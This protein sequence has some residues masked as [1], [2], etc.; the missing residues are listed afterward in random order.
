MRT[1]EHNCLSDKERKYLSPNCSKPPQ[2][3]GLPK[4]HKENIPLRPI[5][6]AFGLPTYRLAK[7]L[8]RI[9]TPL[10]G[11]T[12]T[13]VKNSTEFVRRIK[14]MEPQVGEIIV[15]FDVVSLF[16]KVPIQEAIQAIH[17]RL[18]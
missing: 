12:E 2:I 6:S 14:E 11:G 18:T 5:V 4:V 10:A 9:L 15:S 17:S 7:E 1:L 13:K 8:A 3:Y 16:T